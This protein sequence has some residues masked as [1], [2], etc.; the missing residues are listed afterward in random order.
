MIA[1]NVLRDWLPM[2]IIQQTLGKCLS[3]GE[4]AAYLH[5]DER[6]VRKYHKRLGGVRLSQKTIVFFE[7]RLIDAISKQGNKISVDS[8][9][10]SE[11]KKEKEEMS[12]EKGGY[13]VGNR[14]KRKNVNRAGRDP[15]GL[16]A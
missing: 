7:R 15:F 10:A 16:T 2:D 8:S 6:Q 9:S 14:N 3:V 4:V 1:I 13:N 11:R 5:I 12:H